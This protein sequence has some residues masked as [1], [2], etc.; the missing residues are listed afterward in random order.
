MFD[1]TT[2]FRIQLV[3]R[4]VLAREGLSW[5]DLLV[6]CAIHDLG[7]QSFNVTINAVIQA[8]ALNRCWVYAAI[9]KLKSRQFILV[10]ERKNKPVA[11]SI[12]GLTTLL[13]NR[14]KGAFAGQNVYLDELPG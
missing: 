2:P 14:A 9:R 6:L 8:T 13:I 12:T 10:R 1:T 7:Q 11:V 5:T 4:K 3:K